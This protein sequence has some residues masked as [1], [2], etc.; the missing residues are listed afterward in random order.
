MRRGNGV[1][2][3]GRTFRP[4][5]RIA[6]HNGD[7]A[8]YTVPRCVAQFVDSGRT[9][10]YGDRFAVT[11]LVYAAAALAEIAG[12]WAFWSWLRLGRSP[13]WAL[14]GVVSL[15]TFAWL[16]TRVDQP[17]AARAFAAYGAS[18]LR[19]RW[20]GCAWSRASTPTA[21]TWPAQAFA[22]SGRR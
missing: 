4:E 12:C 1:S 18:T 14:A 20:S 11:A 15:V 19:R 21:G 3:S 7:C 8:L 10:P 16:L 13:A 22:W 5:P 2:R 9:A 6:T 17:H